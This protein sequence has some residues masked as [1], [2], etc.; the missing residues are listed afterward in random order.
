[1]S[2]ESITFNE[3][4]E[5]CTEAGIATDNLEQMEADFRSGRALADVT[6]ALITDQE[7]HPKT[8]S[9]KEALDQMDVHL[10][11]LEEGTEGPGKRGVAIKLAVQVLRYLSEV[12]HDEGRN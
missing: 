12:L 4:M 10:S 6:D 3:F 8:Y 5:L 11:L 2:D 7:T 9:E 1:M